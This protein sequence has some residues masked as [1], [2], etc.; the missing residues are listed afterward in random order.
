[1]IK[2]KF[3]FVTLDFISLSFFVGLTSC[4]SLLY[5]D[6]KPENAGFDVRGDIK[7]GKTFFH[8]PSVVNV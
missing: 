1:M 7:V 2:S 6:T 8:V 4:L 3:F 5:R